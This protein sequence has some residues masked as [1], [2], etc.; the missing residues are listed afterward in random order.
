MKIKLIAVV[1]L[2]GLGF[3]L[4]AATAAPVAAQDDYPTYPTTTLDSNRTPL[5]TDAEILAAIK[6]YR[7]RGAD[8]A[9]AAAAA[10][11]E[12]DAAAA[13]VG[14]AGGG[15]AVLA[16]TGSEHNNI[17]AGGSM[18]ISL[19]AVVALASRRRQ[20]ATS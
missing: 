14:G 19:G 4:F 13:G 8:A 12:A 18:L 3:G 7:N 9:A 6:A 1:A 10:A 17:A 11:V 16:L 2:L 15:Q 20:T 5:P